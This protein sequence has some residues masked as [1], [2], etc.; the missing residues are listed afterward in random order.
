[1]K[2]STKDKTEGTLHQ[3][4]GQV[5]EFTGRIIDS[6]K[7]RIQGTVEKIAGKIQVKIGKFNDL[8]GK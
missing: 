1:M 5:K 4:K 6:P 8:G 3:M 7:L 2:S